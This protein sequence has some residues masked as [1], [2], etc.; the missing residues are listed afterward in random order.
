MSPLGRYPKLTTLK[1]NNQMVFPLD[2]SLTLPSLSSIALHYVREPVRV[3]VEPQPFQYTMVR[4]TSSQ[5]AAMRG[6]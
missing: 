1:L 4:K 2:T 6:W 3:T 5:R